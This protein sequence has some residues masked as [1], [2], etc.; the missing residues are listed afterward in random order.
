MQKKIVKFGLALS[1][2]VGSFVGISP[3]EAVA[4]TCV[5]ICC[6]RSCTSIRDCSGIGGRCICSATCRPADS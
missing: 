4:Q 5:D 3:R 1:M 6:N 2:L